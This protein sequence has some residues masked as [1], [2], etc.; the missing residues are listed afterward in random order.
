MP[1][2]YSLRR[3]FE[4]LVANTGK[5]V[6]CPFKFVQWCDSGELAQKS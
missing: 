2:K 3:R 6:P 1:Q 5:E 4:I